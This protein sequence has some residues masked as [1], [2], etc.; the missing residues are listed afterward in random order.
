MSSAPASETRVV[1]RSRPPVARG[2][3]VVVQDSK[4]RWTFGV[5]RICPGGELIGYSLLGQPTNAANWRVVTERQNYRVLFDLD[6]TEGPEL[7]QRRLDFLDVAGA[8]PNGVTAS[9]VTALV[10]RFNV[11]DA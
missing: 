8:E 10:N 7:L 5:A 4:G 3:I 6:A 2:N 11:T 9:R 1:G